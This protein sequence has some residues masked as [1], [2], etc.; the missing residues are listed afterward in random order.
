MFRRTNIGLVIVV[1]AVWVAMWAMSET[2]I[3][4]G[5]VEATG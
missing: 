4:G 2:A 3:K 1:F 5:S